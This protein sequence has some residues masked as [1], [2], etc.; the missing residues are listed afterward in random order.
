[1]AGGHTAQDKQVMPTSRFLKNACLK[2]G[3]SLAYYKTVSF[4]EAKPVLYH[5]SYT[6]LLRFNLQRPEFF[7]AYTGSSIFSFSCSDSVEQ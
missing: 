1:M 4:L 2:V 3:Q 6:A 5:S 7:I